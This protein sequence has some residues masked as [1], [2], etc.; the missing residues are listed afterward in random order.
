[1][2]SPKYH[3]H[4]TGDFDFS[5]GFHQSPAVISTAE[6]GTL[7]P[8]PSPQYKVGLNA[9][10]KICEEKQ[11]KFHWQ[12]LLKWN[13]AM[14]FKKMFRVTDLFFVKVVITQEEFIDEISLLY[15]AYYFTWL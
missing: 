12:H 15:F 7:Y 1:M 14:C 5:T 13:D 4:L 3:I 2:I 10:E 9:A 6:G 11:E 8:P